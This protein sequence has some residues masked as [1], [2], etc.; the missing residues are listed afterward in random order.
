[1][2]VPERQVP[3]QDILEHPVGHCLATPEIAPVH[4]P[5]VFVGSDRADLGA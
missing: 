2:E 5:D 4:T 3:A 1:M